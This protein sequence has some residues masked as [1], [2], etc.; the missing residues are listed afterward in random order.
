MKA[1]KYKPANNMRQPAK[2]PWLGREHVSLASA[3]SAIR[4]ALC[5]LGLTGC[6]VIALSAA[7]KADSRASVAA[8]GGQ[9]PAEVSRM[10]PMAR[11]NPVGPIRIQLTLK[12]HHTAQLNELLKA[13]QDPTSPQYHRWLQSGEFD[14]RFGPT[15]QDFRAVTNWLGAE[16]FKLTATSFA[17][18]SLQ[19]VGT[20]AQAEHAFATTIMVFGDGTSYSNVTEP[21]L[22]ASIGALVETITGLN[23]FI[24]TRPAGGDRQPQESAPIM[25]AA[26]DS[27][28]AAGQ[29]LIWPD[30]TE[31]FLSRV[32]MGYPGWQRRTARDATSQGHLKQGPQFELG[33]LLGFGPQDVYSFYDE[34]T[35]LSSATGIGGCI[36][37]VG[38]SDILDTG[39]TTFAADFSLP[40]PSFTKVLVDTTSPGTNG[41]EDESQLDLQ[42][43]HATAP[44]SPQ[45]FYLGNAAT[46]SPNG[47]IVDAIQRAVNDNLCQVISVSFGVCGAPASFFTGTL[48]PIY[49][50]AV[51][52]GQTIFVS[53]GDQGAAGIVFDATTKMCVPATSRNVNE[54]GA[55]PNVI[56]VGGTGF[57]PNFDVNGNNVGNVPESAWNDEACCAGGATGGG[58]SAVYAKPAYQSGTGVPADGR[59]DVPDIALI[60]SNNFP[61]VWWVT[62]FF[63]SPFLNCCIGGT[64]LSA[65][66]WGGLVKVIGQKQGGRLGRINDKLYQLARAG[67]ATNGFR[68]VND[69]SN[70]GFNGV[71][72]FTAGTG[73]DQCTRL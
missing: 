69:L 48:S 6:L 65:P 17:D 40:A 14:A 42:W 51:A 26:P 20:I 55:D 46:S 59:R 8:L 38:D 27:L 63:G 64:S 34:S 5:A 4:V 52:Q 32:V 41:D 30:A 2:Y 33:G 21:A 67:L 3:V 72:G 16:G 60:A 1:A 47:P 11:A 24:H 7:A 57:T 9:V 28:V 25:S 56:A 12:L 53:S 13:Q 19:A 15:P 22:P 43:S 70:N 66:M 45:R 36:A 49:A 58:A 31:G 29:N 18:H 35:L 73:Y 68:D 10:V 50:K 39:P 54:M 37:I 62:D 23:N 61:G 44:G 71:T